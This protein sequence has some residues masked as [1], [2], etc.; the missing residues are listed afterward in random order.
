MADMAVFYKVMATLGVRPKVFFFYNY[1][2]GSCGM[3]SHSGKFGKVEQV[4]IQR[5]VALI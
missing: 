3:Q 4:Q 5:Q 1:P 2:M